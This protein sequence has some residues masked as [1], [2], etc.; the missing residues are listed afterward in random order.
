MNDNIR[1]RFQAGTQC[2]LPS[3]AETIRP[4]KGL[5]ASFSTLWVVVVFPKFILLIWQEKEFPLMKV[6]PD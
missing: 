6:M 2:L 3:F 1:K 5:G 4:V